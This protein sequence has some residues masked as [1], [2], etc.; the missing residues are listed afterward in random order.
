MRRDF[1]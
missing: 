1:E